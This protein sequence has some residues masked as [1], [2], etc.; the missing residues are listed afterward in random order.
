MSSARARA[1]GQAGWGP[2]E[3]QRRGVRPARQQPAYGRGRQGLDSRGSRTLVHVRGPVTR[4]A[5]PRA[6]RRAWGWSRACRAGAT[7]TQP[8]T[9]T[10]KASQ[11]KTGALPDLLVPVTIT[12]TFC[13][14]MEVMME[15]SS[16]PVVAVYLGEMSRT[17][18]MKA[19]VGTESPSVYRLV[20]PGSDAAAAAQHAPKHQTTTVKAAVA[21][22][23]V[24]HPT[25]VDMADTGPLAAEPW[26]RCGSRQSR[27]RHGTT[28]KNWYKRIQTDTMKCSMDSPVG[29]CCGDVMERPGGAVRIRW[30]LLRAGA[31]GDAVRSYR[32]LKPHGPLPPGPPLSFHLQ[33]L[34][35]NSH[36][37]MTGNR[38]VISWPPWSLPP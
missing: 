6:C 10:T 32:V 35:Q 11:A 7:S 19:K 8:P 4:G 34:N 31:P 2:R 28:G 29:N 9:S 18:S 37:D 1:C 23:P 25:A 17:W 14:S 16:C 22:M 15:C 24:R 27:T 26:P 20:H 3:G 12:E 21:R 30:Q 33:T 5:R 36:T 38:Q 13:P